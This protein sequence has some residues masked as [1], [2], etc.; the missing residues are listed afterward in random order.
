MSQR[1][2]FQAPRNRVIPLF[3]IF[4]LVVGLIGYRV[5]SVQVVRSGE[6]SRWAVAE[7][8]Q[9]NVVPARRGEIY[10]AHGLRLATNAPANRVS[11][12]IDQITDKR[13][14]AG[15]LASLLGRSAEE[16]EIALNQPD[17]EWV[18][19]ARHLSPAQSAQVAALGLDGI[20]L[21]PEPSRVYPFGAF[22]SHVLGFTNDDMQGNYGIEG[23]YDEALT[24][25]PGRL[26]GERDAAGNVIGLTHSSWDSPLDGA[27]LVLTLDSAVQRAIEEVLD[28]VVKEQDALGGTII[29]Q[30]TRTGAIL[31][32]ANRSTF[33]PNRYGD[34]ADAASYLN[35][36][37]SAIYEPGSTFKSIVMAVGIDSGAVTPETTHNDEPGYIAL[38]DGSRIRNFEDAIFGE[39]TMTRV[40]QV[41]SNLGA[42][43]VAEEIGQKRFYESLQEFGFGVPTGVEL[44]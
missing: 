22:A 25:T 35:P 2:P 27:D 19:L 33:N 4:V 29:V 5:V 32:L 18:L 7:R 43:F 16:I 36:A 44:E 31:G 17:L 39:L 23:R 41:S 28:T 21:D 38:E 24:G 40:L 34:V 10:D 3:F 1:P 12:I 26:V 37:I 8:M 42:V 11:A 20:V 9:E 14:V 30:D 6:F 13:A 15:Q